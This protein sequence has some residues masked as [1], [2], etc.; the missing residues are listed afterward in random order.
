MEILNDSEFNNVSPVV[1]AVTD[2]PTAIAFITS[3][4][5]DADNNLDST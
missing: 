5:G 4:C 2:V 3:V 1:G